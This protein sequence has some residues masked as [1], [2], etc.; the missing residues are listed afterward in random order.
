[1]VYD[2][3]KEKLADSTKADREMYKVTKVKI[4]TMDDGRWMRDERRRAGRR[5]L[6][7]IDLV[8]KSVQIHSRDTFH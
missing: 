7:G 5:L 1:M 4:R 6:I 8:Y 3:E 2:A